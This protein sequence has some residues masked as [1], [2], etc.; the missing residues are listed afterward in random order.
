MGSLVAELCKTSDQFTEYLWN[1]AKR[2]IHSD[3]GS[4]GFPYNKCGIIGQDM[5]PALVEFWCMPSAIHGYGIFHS[6]KR[7][8]NE[9]AVVSL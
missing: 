4:T 8:S 7:N 1:Q 9:Y 2:M 6:W 5:D 3:S